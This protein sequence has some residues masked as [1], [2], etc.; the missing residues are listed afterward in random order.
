MAFDKIKKIYDEH[1]TRITR[2]KFLVFQVI[3]VTVDIGT[4]FY[5]AVQHYK[6]VLN[7]NNFEKGDIVWGLPKSPIQLIQTDTD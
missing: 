1:Q 4:D 7:F 5:T 2:L 3:L 6:Y